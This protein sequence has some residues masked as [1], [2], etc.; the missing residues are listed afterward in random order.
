MRDMAASTVAD[1]F[2]AG[3]V[4]RFGCPA[5]VTSDRGTQFSSVIWQLMCERLGISHN[6]TTAYHPQSNGM[7]ERAHR[8]LKNSLRSRMATGDWSDHLPWVLMGLRAAPKED[9]G[10]SSAELLLGS[11]M[12]L[13]GEI[14]SSPDS[15]PSFFIEQLRSGQPPPPTRPLAASGSPAAPTS[16]LLQSELVYI[17]RGGSAPPLSP[18]YMGPYKVITAGPKYFDIAVGDRTERVSVDRLKPHLGRAPV[19]PA[20]PARRGRPPRPSTAS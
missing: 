17:K 10:L 12:T 7:I 3:W 14:L 6:M 2:I 18:L 13:P 20:T 8:Q 9:C 5:T 11:P 16:A 19:Q 1:A 4:A 15:P